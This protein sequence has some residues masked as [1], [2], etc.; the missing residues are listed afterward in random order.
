MNKID[1][2][3]QKL[4]TIGLKT[5]KAFFSKTVFRDVV[6][7]DHGRPAVSIMPNKPTSLNLHPLGTSGGA[8]SCWSIETLPAVASGWL[9]L[10]PSISKYPS[11]FSELCMKDS[12]AMKFLKKRMRRTSFGRTILS[13]FAQVF[14]CIHHAVVL[15]HGA[16]SRPQMS[17]IAVFSNWPIVALTRTRSLPYTPYKIQNCHIDFFKKK[18]SKSFV[19]FTLTLL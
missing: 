14:F 10:L 7:P 19:F 15:P 17:D 8:P 9:K 11:A 2:I 13:F 4:L 6:L 3:I 1:V 16:R 12:S 18:I 5:Y